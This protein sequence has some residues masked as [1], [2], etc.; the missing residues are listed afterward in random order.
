MLVLQRRL[1]CLVAVTA[2]VVLCVLLVDRP[3]A[4]WVDAHLYG[5]TVFAIALAI[6]RPLDGLLLA[7]AVL[8]VVA[9][10]WR[11]LSG[12]PPWLNRL[13][14]G[15]AG[16]AAALLAALALKV[17]IGRSQVYPPFL[18]DHVYG[19]QPFAASTDFMAFPSATM[20][21]AA[22]LIAGLGVSRAL[23]RVVAAVVLIALAAAIVITAGHWLSDV[24]GGT[25]LGLVTGATVARRLR[26]R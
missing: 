13:I 21:G 20:A 23:R 6:L 15:G 4:L 19:F 25:Y 26:L 11:R 2:T 24:I 7:A 3:V 12:A 10:I 14:T 16:A 8:L 1:A 17:A 22:G 5:T 9:V 18:H